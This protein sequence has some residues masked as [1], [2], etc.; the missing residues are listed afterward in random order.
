MGTLKPVDGIWAKQ[1]GV[2][3]GFVP[4][5]LIL[6]DNLDSDWRRCVQTLPTGKP[7]PPMIGSLTVERL[8][9]VTMIPPCPSVE[10]DPA[11]TWTFG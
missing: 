8:P 2:Y 4:G 11:P 5:P 7:L 10:A 1:I 3:P 6:R 9:V